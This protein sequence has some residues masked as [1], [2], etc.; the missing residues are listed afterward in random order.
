MWKS[1]AKAREMEPGV[2]QN[3]GIEPDKVNRVDI[4]QRPEGQLLEEWALTP[5][6]E[7]RSEDSRL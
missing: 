1:T 3:A 5:K 2:V 6:G 7:G 4:P